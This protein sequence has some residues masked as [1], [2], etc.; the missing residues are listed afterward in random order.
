MSVGGNGNDLIDVHTHYVPNGWPDL[1]VTGSDA[2]WLQIESESDAVVMFGTREFRRIK[3]NSWDAVRK[4]DAKIRA[5]LVENAA[6]NHRQDRKMGF[7]WRP[8]P[9]MIRLSQKIAN[10]A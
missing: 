9:D 6:D 7:G 8:R 4:T 5:D 10:N 2:P 3:S 1:G